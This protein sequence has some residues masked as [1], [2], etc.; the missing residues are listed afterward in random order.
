MSQLLLKSID[1]KMLVP[2]EL[3]RTFERR[4]LDRAGRGG[5]DVEERL[6]GLGLE[7]QVVLRGT[8]AWAVIRET[9]ALLD[10]PVIRP[11]GELARERVADGRDIGDSELGKGVTRDE[12]APRTNRNPS[13]KFGPPPLGWEGVVYIESSLSKIGR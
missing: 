1:P 7:V 9:A 11:A 12:A 3:D 6:V 4:E 10:R 2:T 8:A 5:R 13:T